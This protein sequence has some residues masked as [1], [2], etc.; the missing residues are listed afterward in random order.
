MI[1]ADGLDRAV[2]MKGS[3]Q[4]VCHGRV[5]A[6]HD[7]LS[8]VVRETRTP[9]CPGGRSIL[10]RGWQ[11]SALSVSRLPFPM[12]SRRLASRT[13]R[14]PVQDDRMDDKSADVSANVRRA[15]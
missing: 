7:T 5:I 8:L 13:F 3:R 2:H 11:R 14:D 9:I 12:G 6:A 4:G 1:L 15:R 10:A